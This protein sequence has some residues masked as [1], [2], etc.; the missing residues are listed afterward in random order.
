ME[1]NANKKKVRCKRCKGFGHFAKKCK[2]LQVGDD[3]ETAATVV[4]KRYLCSVKSICFCT[5]YPN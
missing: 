5:W 3:G 2:L 1:Q 4:K